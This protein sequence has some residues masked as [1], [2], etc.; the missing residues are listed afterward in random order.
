MNSETLEEI[1][2]LSPSPGSGPG[3][4]RMT[5]GLPLVDA[6]GRTTMIKCKHP[7]G[8][9]RSITGQ[10]LHGATLAAHRVDPRQPLGFAWLLGWAFAEVV[11]V[12]EDARPPWR[13]AT[14]W[15]LDFDLLLTWLRRAREPAGA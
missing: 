1:L 14:A 9:W 13:M 11:R 12:D 6:D 4:I 3:Q 5:P 2:D 8:G 7:A 15:A 10:R